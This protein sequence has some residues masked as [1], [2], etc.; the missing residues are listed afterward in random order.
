MI[1]IDVRGTLAGI[2]YETMR[3]VIKIKTKNSSIA[4]ALSIEGRVLP[5]HVPLPWSMIRGK[6]S[7]LEFVAEWFLRCRRLWQWDATGRSA[8]YFQRL[9][10]N[11]ANER[12]TPSMDPT[13]FYW[14][15]YILIVGRKLNSQTLRSTCKMSFQILKLYWDPL[16]NQRGFHRTDILR[17]IWETHTTPTWRS[18][19]RGKRAAETTWC[20]SVV[21]P[22]LFSYVEFKCE[23]G[24]HLTQRNQYY[25][26]ILTPRRT[27]IRRT[28]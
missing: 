16:L 8:W 10:I 17:S 13:W 27:Y 7:W 11:S 26:Y 4:F 24:A 22:D 28:F 5:W 6:W 18:W 20:L 25:V 19:I 2:I 3:R 23:K 1:S 15:L 9:H 21:A 14:F 12:S